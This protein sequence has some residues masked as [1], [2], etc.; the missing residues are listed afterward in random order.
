MTSPAALIA[1]FHEMEAEARADFTRKTGVHGS[2][3]PIEDLTE[4]ARRAA[5]HHDWPEG[6]ALDVIGN[7]FLKTAG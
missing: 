5:R 4:C 1:T 6:D 2:L 3:L 7:S